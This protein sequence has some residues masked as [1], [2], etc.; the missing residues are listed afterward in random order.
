MQFK[1]PYDLPIARKRVAYAEINNAMHFAMLK[2]LAT[3]D[4]QLI[5][6]MFDDVIAETTGEDPKSMF[7]LD[8]FCLLMD[9][10]SITMGDRVELRAQHARVTIMLS[11][12]INNTIDAI[13][14]IEFQHDFNI[15]GIT[16]VTHMPR[17]FIANDV[18][19]L[20]HN[21]I[22]M[23]QHGDDAHMMHAMSTQERDT[24]IN[25][26]PAQATQ[27]IIQHVKINQQST[28]NIN[29]IPANNMAGLDAFPLNIYDGSMLL[30]AKSM[31][32]ED[33]M[34]FY[35]MHY[36][37]IKKLELSNDHFMS[38]TPNESRIFVNLHNKDMKKQQE[39]HDRQQQPG[40]RI[41]RS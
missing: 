3:D 35:E 7:V 39:E 37:I 11:S 15:D 30:F 6:Q 10:R 17:K 36:N 20:V 2:Y 25:S 18:E 38:M 1:I 24:L 21:S 33:L 14:N 8:K 5:E 12:I 28:S 23:I 4:I 32:Q 9:M 27:Q 22:Y 26:L 40:G 13:S 41:S 29:I 31:F 19:Q 34:N 16:I